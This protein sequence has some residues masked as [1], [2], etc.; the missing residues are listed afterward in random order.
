MSA[1]LL[2]DLYAFHSDWLFNSKD[3]TNSLASK[4]GLYTLLLEAV[5]LPVYAIRDIPR[6]TEIIDT[7]II[8][9]ENLLMIIVVHILWNFPIIGNSYTLKHLRGTL[10]NYIPNFE[11]IYYKNLD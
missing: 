2:P 7:E 10:N 8:A 6:A 5:V 1:G 9:K 4:K 11:I 3:R